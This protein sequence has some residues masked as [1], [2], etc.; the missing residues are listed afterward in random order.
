[1]ARLA[2][3]AEPRVAIRAVQFLHACLMTRDPHYV[4]VL[5]QGDLLAPAIATLRSASCART[6]VADAV[7]ELIDMVLTV[8]SFAY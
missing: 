5:M 1:M 2:G 7:K 4:V 6:E 3:H 8:S